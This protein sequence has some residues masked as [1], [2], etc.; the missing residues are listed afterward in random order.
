[1]SH[2]LA[3]Q[4]GAPRSCGPAIRVAIDRLNAVRALGITVPMKARNSVEPDRV[5]GALRQPRQGSGHQPHANGAPDRDAR[6]LRP[7][8][9]SHRTGRD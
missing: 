9:R 1:M 4:R 6:G 2:A 8:S 3:A 5:L 7:L